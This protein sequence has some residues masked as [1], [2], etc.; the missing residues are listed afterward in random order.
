[1]ED[2]QLN[3]RYARGMQRRVLHRQQERSTISH[4]MAMSKSDV[5]KGRMGTTAGW[6]EERFNRQQ[7]YFEKE[8]GFALEAMNMR[9][10]H[11]R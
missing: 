11:F 5:D 8:K 9:E 10:K 4:A 2:S 3:L 7:T 6:D 1:M